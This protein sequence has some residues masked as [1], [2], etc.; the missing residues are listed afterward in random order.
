MS[1]V[2]RGEMDGLERFGYTQGGASDQQ[3]SW[4][5]EQTRLMTNLVAMGKVLLRL[6]V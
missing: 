1:E 6:L 5:W 3:N 4:S 2:V